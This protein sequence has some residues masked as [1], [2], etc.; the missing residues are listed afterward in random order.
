MKKIPLFVLAVLL[1]SIS[2]SQ[3][4]DNKAYQVTGP[5]LELTDSTIVVQKGT[6]KWVLARSPET[7]VNGDLKVGA[8]VTV[9]YRMTANSVDVA[10]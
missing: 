1:F 7:K 4:A 2:I 3:A 10:K 6:E 5:I 9:Y 8:K